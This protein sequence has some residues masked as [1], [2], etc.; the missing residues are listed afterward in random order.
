MQ[1]GGGGIG[2]DRTRSSFLK[3]LCNVSAISIHLVITSYSITKTSRH[4][5][6]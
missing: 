5:W 3:L 1:A 2:A 6:V 4:L